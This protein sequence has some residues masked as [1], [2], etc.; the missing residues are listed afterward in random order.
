M[1]I[2]A[3]TPSLC[4]SITN[5]HARSYLIP[6]DA[7]RNL[8]VREGFL[9]K[10]TYEER[11]GVDK[12]TGHIVTGVIFDL[13]ENPI[14]PLLKHVS[15]QLLQ[16]RLCQL[17]T[18]TPLSLDCA[19]LVAQYSISMEFLFG[20]KIYESDAEINFVRRV[21][22]FCREWGIF[23]LG[24]FLAL[25]EPEDMFWVGGATKSAESWESVVEAA[26]CGLEALG[27]AVSLC[28]KRDFTCGCKWRRMCED[29]EDDSLPAKCDA[30]AVLTASLDR[31][32]KKRLKRLKGERKEWQRRAGKK[33]YKVVL[34]RF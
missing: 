13:H 17:S 2:P 15:N 4:A 5:L 16:T 11:S 33:S 30:I 29:G 24:V 28:D 27:L 14:R 8:L 6:R 21:I 9:T 10:R 31:E 34:K 18:S 1:D 12:K 25:C 23:G 7:M 32:E 19:G 26:S 22:D 20:V 3:V